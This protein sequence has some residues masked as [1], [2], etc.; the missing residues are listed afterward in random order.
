MKKEGLEAEKLGGGLSLYKRNVCGRPYPLIKGNCTSHS[1]SCASRT[2]QCSGTSVVLAG[3]A[4]WVG[5]VS[6]GS[7]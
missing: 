1:R 3:V 5:E 6:N 7:W 4:A 2:P